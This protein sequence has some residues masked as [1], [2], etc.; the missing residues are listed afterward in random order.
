MKKIKII[1]IVVII[2]IIAGA[3]FWFF[4]KK[5]IDISPN[6]DQQK[7][8]PKDETGINPITGEKCENYNRRPIAVMMAN[9]AINRPL[10]GISQADVIIEMPVIT[11]GITR[12][13]AIYGCETPKEI[14]SVRS[15]RHDYIPLALGFNAIYAHWG[16]SHF[17]YDQLNKGI[18]ENID[19]MTDQY[20]AYYRTSDKEPPYNGFTSLERLINAAKKFGY[21][22]ENNFSGYPHLKNPKSKIQNPNTGGKLTIGYGG[23]FRVSYAYNKEENVYQRYRTNLRET[24][25]NNGN[26]AEV[27]VV[28]VM[29]AESHMIEVPNYNEVD[30]QGEGEAKIYQNGEEIKGIWKKTGNYSNSKLTFIGEN[31]K[32][33]EFTPGKIWI[34]I[35]EPNTE[36]KWETF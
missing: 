15:A 30:V 29:R 8:E 27:S 2:L 14:G 5:N 28:A 18:I 17:A 25:K 23:E 3:I 1:L 19:A 10:S 9:D 22:L 33:I 16:G 26:Q 12:L 31:G 7:E 6:G 24:D 34:E 20:Q 35:V 11:G 36:V 32:E 13:M 4:G 21:S